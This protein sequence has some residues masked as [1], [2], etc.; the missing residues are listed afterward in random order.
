MDFQ[1]A[2]RT[3]GYRYRGM[4]ERVRD[5]IVAGKMDML[6]GAQEPII[7]EAMLEIGYLD[8]ELNITT[9][10]ISSREPADGDITPIVEYFC[11]AKDSYDWWMDGYIADNIDSENCKVNVDFAADDWQEQLERDMF[12]TLVW[13]AEQCGFSFNK[14]NS[15]PRHMCMSDSPKPST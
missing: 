13:Y 3:P 1:T 14:P 8:L 6:Y 12:D 9:P 5:Q 7:A 2:K 15:M 4:S 10:E 11:C